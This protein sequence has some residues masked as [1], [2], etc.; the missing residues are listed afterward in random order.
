MKNSEMEYDLVPLTD[1]ELV[2]VQ[3]NLDEH[4]LVLKQ[5]ENK[6]KQLQYQLDND[7]PT[8]RDKLKLIEIQDGLKEAKSE[9]KKAEKENNQ[10]KVDVLKGTI[11]SIEDMIA[12]QKERINLKLSQRGTSLAINRFDKNPEYI[13]QKL[14]YKMYKD[15]A[16]NKVRKVLKMQQ[17]AQL[18]NKEE[19]S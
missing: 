14:Q 18:D 9:L 13:K 10:D 4:K 17:R 11:L 7:I 6:K 3:Y 16:R 8:K 1:L 12:A 5:N 2:E 19:S 15:Q